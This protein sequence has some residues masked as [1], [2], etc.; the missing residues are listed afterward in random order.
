MNGEEN[1]HEKKKRKRRFSIIYILSG[2]ILKEEFVVKHTRMIVLV[3]IMALFYVGNR[4]TCLLKLREIDRLQQQLKDAKYESLT[5]SGQLT[6]S[7]R[8]S[9]IEEWVKK[10]GLALEDAKAPPYILHR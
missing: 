4:Y 6:G 5:I 7:N 3:V 1:I 8:Q 9:Q 2:G 10:Q